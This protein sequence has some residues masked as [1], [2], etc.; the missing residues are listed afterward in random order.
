MVCFARAAPA[1][2][3]SNRHTGFLRKIRIARLR[4][5]IP[6]FFQRNYKPSPRRE[7]VTLLTIVAA[8]CKPLE[9][10]LSVY[11]FWIAYD[12]ITALKSGRV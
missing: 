4:R 1:K 11:L 12:I 9:N 2:Y 3:K 7:A 10:G 8:F 6:D 5:G